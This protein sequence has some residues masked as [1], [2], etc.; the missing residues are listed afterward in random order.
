M[1]E[2]DV[3]GDKEISVKSARSALSVFQT[4]RAKRQKHKKAD[5]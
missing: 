2:Q 3:T 4:Q 5:K 1:N